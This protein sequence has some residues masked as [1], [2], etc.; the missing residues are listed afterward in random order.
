[1]SMALL[2]AD[3]LV[4]LHLLFIV[5]VMAG[6]FLLGRW[7]RV[8]WV[9]LPAAAWGAFVEFSGVICP[10][11]PLE[12]RLRVLG[13][14]SAY[15]GGFVERYLLPLI[16]PEHLTP[17]IQQALGVIVVLVNLAAYAWVWHARRRRRS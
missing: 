16:Y 11:T 6:G 3:A 4:V 15:G 8:A 5:F 2:A 12:N 7:P 14:G 13:G 9:H 1:M 10:L 17:A